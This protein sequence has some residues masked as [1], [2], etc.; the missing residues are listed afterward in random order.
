MRIPGKLNLVPGLL[1]LL[2]AAFLC[3]AAEPTTN[4]YT[5]KNWWKGDRSPFSPVVHEDSTVT[6]RVKAPHAHRIELLLG[7][8]QT[9][10]YDLA[11]GENNIWSVKTDPL[12]PG[13]YSYNF[14]IDGVITL[15]RHNPQSKIGTLVYGSV[16][17]IPGNP[18]R[19]DEFQ[20]VPSGVDHIHSFYST[21]LQCKRS[22]YVHTPPNYKEMEESYPVL[23]LRHGGGDKASSWLQDGHAGII[24]DNLIAKEKAKSMIIV[25]PD[26]LT[27]GS[28]AGGSDPEGM[29]IL[30]EELF[31]VIMP[32]IEKEYRVKTTPENTAIAG[33]SMGG[34]QAVLIGLKHPNQF[35]WI[36]EFSSG[37]MSAVEFNIE[38]RIPG[39][40]GRAD[41]L[42]DSLDLI[43]LACGTEDPRYQGHVEFANLLSNRGFDITFHD[44]PGGHEWNVWRHELKNFLQRLFS[45][46]N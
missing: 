26:S 6:F 33:L 21:R 12:A 17:E 15:D 36:G 27:D 34:G 3:Q 38:S 9:E 11:K 22:F 7:E 42:N 32:L 20:V 45:H 29:A 4:T 25:M 13:I 35:N 44:M 40:L 41:T 46:S 39:V 2:L 14:K 43:Y 10:H 37:L 18:A 23:Y 30:E 1:A 16:L 31:Q 24:L 19:F 28:W 5:V 8:W